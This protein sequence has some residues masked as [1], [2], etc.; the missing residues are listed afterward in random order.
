MVYQFETSRIPEIHG[1]ASLLHS[2][3]AFIVCNRYFKELAVFIH[4]ND[5]IKQ[6]LC[7]RVNIYP[8]EGALFVGLK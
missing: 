1:F 3:F 8:T 5:I 2:K 6:Y 4:S 7:T